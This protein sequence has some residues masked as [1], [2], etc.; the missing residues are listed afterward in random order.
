VTA[1]DQEW[2]VGRVPAAE[3]AAV[4]PRQELD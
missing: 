1:G 3:H 2:I 4:R